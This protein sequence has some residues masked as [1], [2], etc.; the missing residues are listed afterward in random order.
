HE[1]LQG[2][3]RQRHGWPPPLIPAVAG[4][5]RPPGRRAPA[6]GQPS[7]RTQPDLLRMSVSSPC[8]TQNWT[9]ALPSL[10]LP[11]EPGST[12]SIVNVAVWLLPLQTNLLRWLCHHAE[13]VFEDPSRLRARS[14][15]PDLTSLA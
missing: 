1:G 4:A 2:L 5:R 14:F 7:T 15:L 3:R 6:A 11:F 13:A 12:L 8:V 9:Q 10:S